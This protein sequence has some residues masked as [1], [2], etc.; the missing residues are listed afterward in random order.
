MTGARITQLRVTAASLTDVGRRRDHNEDAYGVEESL[1]A[2]VVC[3]GMGG[4]ASGEV[5]S[6]MTVDHLIDFLR[7]RAAQGPDAELP[8]PVLDGA[9]LEEAVLSNAVQHAND[10]VYIEG[11]KDPK[12]EGMGTTIVAML[13]LPDR[14]VVAHVGDSRVYRYSVDGLEHVTRD[15]SLLNHKIDMGELSTPDEIA[16]FKQGNIIVR[17]IGLK[18]YVT[19]ETQ[20]V[21]RR[22]GDCYLLCSDGLTD[23]VDDWSIQNVLEANADDL[24]EAAACL[25]R[26]ANDR[27]GKDNITVMLVRIDDLVA[28]HRS[29]PDA[30]PGLFHEEDTQPGLDVVEE[31]TDP[32]GIAAVDAEDPA[33]FHEMPTDPGR[34]AVE[35]D[36]DTG[37]L[38]ETGGRRRSPPEPSTLPL[39]PAVPPPP[40]VQVQVQ[41][42]SANLQRSKAKRPKKTAGEPPSIIV[43]QPSI[44]IDMD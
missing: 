30:G 39:T 31:P 13:T 16:N 42:G 43:E 2:Y 34:P 12:L 22:S 38:V 44:I 6:R 36:A 19:P 20:T 32:R 9:T 10:R 4:H 14:L 25:V 33:A 29:G 35:L 27:G 26:M 18:D 40:A 5:A 28:S 15:H 8:H 3:D 21:A 1:G 7:Q 17:A 41:G 23:M 37:D 24:A 11:M